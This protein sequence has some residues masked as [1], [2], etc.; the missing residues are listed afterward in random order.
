MSISGAGFLSFGRRLGWLLLAST[1]VAA[2]GSAFAAERVIS[3]GTDVFEC[4]NIDPGDVLT[5]PS[6]TRGELTIRNCKATAAN[7]IVVRNDPRGN[8]PTIIRRSGGSSGGF[9][10]SCNTCI[11]V[12]IDGSY[13]WQGAPSGKT[14]GIQITMTGGGAPTSFMKIGGL[15]R[16]VTVRNVE[17]DGKWP[18]IAKSG[19]G[20]RLNDLQIRRSAYPGLWRE[21]ILFE[22]NYIHDV[23]NEGMYIG[24]NYSDGDLPLRDIEIRN[25][26]V[27]DI[28][29][30]A[31]N[32]KSMWVGDNRIHHNVVRRAGKNGI[33]SKPTQ[34]SG[35]NNASGTVKIYNNWIETTG[36]HGI[37][38]WTQQGPKISENKGPFVA[39]IYNN[40]IVDAGGLWRSFMAKSTGI[41]IGAQDGCEKPLPRI[42]SNTIVNSRQTGIMIATNVGDGFVRDNIA[43]GSG[44][45]PVIIVPK[46][47]EIRNNNVG[48]VAQM[49]FVNPSSSNY[50]LKVGSPARN[51]GTE[52]FP[53]K[54]FG[55]VARP[56]DGAA[57]QGAF[58]GG[59]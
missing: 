46:W 17:I 7:P 11:G 52:N 16:F 44:T 53:A 35:I 56:K 34:Y 22:D 8:G 31:I 41:N 33:S 25:N 10:F 59:G 57:D 2:V 27:E 21:G 36:Q 55:D 42:Y 37:Q 12:V 1:L 43:A 23:A 13:K 38:S 30:E 20:V 15:S 9:L 18:A 4:G 40:V 45:N 28:G 19:A 5:L 47:V 32:T 51:Q 39:E 48:S 3:P 58:E 6:G 14:Y 49:D 50:R 29:W 54:D 26:R 24:A